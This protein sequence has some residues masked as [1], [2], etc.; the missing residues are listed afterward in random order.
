MSTS[1][2]SQQE[3]EGIARRIG[4]LGFCFR[5]GQHFGGSGVLIFSPPVRDSDIPVIER[6]VFIYA[7]GSR[8]EARLTPHGGPHWTLEVESVER[9][10]EVAL[11]ALRSATVPP[12]S[13]WKVER[14]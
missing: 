11:E 6:G 10:E 5:L 14:A 3:L 13:E 2:D 9:L 7:R 12:T 8:W 1:P 4:E